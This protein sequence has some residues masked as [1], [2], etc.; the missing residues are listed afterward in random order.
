M[1]LREVEPARLDISAGA[2]FRFRFRLPGENGGDEADGNLIRSVEETGL[3]CPPVLL[4]TAGRLEIVSGF[5]RV[6]AARELGLKTIPALVTAAGPD[7]HPGAL[8]VWL[9]SSLHGLGLS[10]M[11]KMTLAVKA[12]GM[13]RGGLD[14]ILQ[15]ISAVFGRRIDAA[16]LERFRRLSGLESC[17]R[18]AV[19]EGRISAGDLLRLDSHLGVET[20]PAARLLAESGLSRSARREAVR[21]FLALADRGGDVLSRFIDECSGGKAPLDEAVRK[22][23]HPRMSGDLSSLRGSASGMDLP[24][25]AS[26]NFP[27]NLEGG[28]LTVE[29]KVRDEETLSMALSRL[30]R[31]LDEGVVGKM[32]DVLKGRS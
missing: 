8:D 31:G 32:L 22:A 9:E 15:R 24:P 23:A 27:E 2:P 12:A 5:R 18:A 20:A 1:E 3:I 13:S 29:I 19:H 6:A 4:D 11:E 14:D 25:G 10:E 17:I 21:G 28:Y 7:R 16:M 30:G 26:I